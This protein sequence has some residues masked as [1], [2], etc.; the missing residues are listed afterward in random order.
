M[1]TL[2]KHKKNG[3]AGFKKFVRSLESMGDKT[4]QK[5]VQIA[6]LEDPVYLMAA[7]SNIISF[8][9]L[10]SFDKEEKQKIYNSVNGGMQTL[11]F[12]LRGHPR[13]SEF[14]NHLA[15]NTISKYKEESEYFRPAGPGQMLTAQKSF[16]AAMRSLQENFSI[17]PFSWKLPS[18]SI[19][20]GLDFSSGPSSGSFILNYDSGSIALE[21]EI[22]RRLRVGD[23]KHYYPN[24]ELM[25]EGVYISSEKEGPWIF[26]YANGEI[27]SKGDY[28][29]DLKNGTWEEYDRDGLMVEI[30]YKR[31]KADL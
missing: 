20:N 7:L 16:L 18:N 30:I 12:A 31:G 3:E 2:Q 22:E 10:F 15:T 29:E 4:R 11:L 8:E 24:S 17:S 14:V 6:I 26:Y 5:V 13:E 25:A 23:W 19:L 21:G 1:N 9:Y 27:K 28:H